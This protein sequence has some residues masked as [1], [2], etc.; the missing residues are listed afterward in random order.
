MLKSGEVEDDIAAFADLKD[1][2]CL[3]ITI[4]KPGENP[5]REPIMTLTGTFLVWK[6]LAFK[7]LDP[8]QSIMQ[9]LLKLEG[10]MTLALKYAKAAMELANV[11]EN[12]DTS[13]FTNYDLGEE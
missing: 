4:I 10:D 2:K 13:L 9:G 5:P 3:G 1:G 7:E 8:I 6:Q 11:V 12:T